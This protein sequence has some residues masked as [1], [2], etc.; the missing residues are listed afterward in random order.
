MQSQALVIKGEEEYQVAAIYLKSFVE[1][2]KNIMT[3]TEPERKAKYAEY[4]VVQ[5]QQK[6]YLRPI[7]KGERVLRQKMG[8]YNRE[9]EVLRQK[10][11]AELQEQAEEQGIDKELVSI[12]KEPEPEGISYRKVMDF[13]VLD[14]SQVPDTFKLLN[15]PMVRRFAKDG[16]AIPGIEFFEKNVAVVR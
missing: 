10:V 12:P 15:E 8:E 7:E 6:D 5:T 11:L 16:E 4:K 14:F 13:R 3:L 2:K 9:Q 1:I